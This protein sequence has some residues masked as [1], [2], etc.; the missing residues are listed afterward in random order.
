MLSRSGPRRSGIGAAAAIAAGPIGAKGHAATTRLRAPAGD[1]DP[2][3]EHE[4]PGAEGE[5][6]AGHQEAGERCPW[7]SQ[8]SSVPA[9]PRTH[10]TPLAHASTRL[11]GSDPLRVRD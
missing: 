8:T 9:S 3:R 7:V 6:R 11:K 10:P 1:D 2:E 5:L 4:S